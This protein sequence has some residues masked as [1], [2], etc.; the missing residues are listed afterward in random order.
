VYIHDGKWLGPASGKYVAKPR[1]E[2]GDK[3]WL[4]YDDVAL[5]LV[6]DLVEAK[7]WKNTFV[8]PFEAP[9]KSVK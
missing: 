6:E 7:R 1:L 9:G 3:W 8:V 2:K 4:H 5:F